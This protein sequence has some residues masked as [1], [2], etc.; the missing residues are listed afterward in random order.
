[1][2]ISSVAVYTFSNTISALE[3][4]RLFGP[5]THAGLQINC[6]VQD[7][8]FTTDVISKSDIT[9]FQREF[10]GNFYSFQAVMA[11]AGESGKQVV[12]DLDD[13]LLSLPLSHPDELK[14]YFA[15]SQLPMLTAM[16]QVK[17]L[18]VTTQY[19]ANLLK[20]YN[21]N[22]YVLP[23]YL[24][25]KIWRFNSP[26]ISTKKKIRIIYMGGITH[27]HDLKML[28]PAIRILA[29]KYPDKL[30]FIFYGANLE[31]PELLPVTIT[32]LAS[33]T[34]VYAD[35][36]RVALTQLADIAIA[37]LEDNDFNRCKSNIKYLEYTA[38]GLPG[39]FSNV[40]PYSSVIKQGSNGFVA[41]STDDWVKAISQLIDDPLLRLQ[42]ANEAQENV[43][44]N[45]LMSDHAHLWPETLAEISKLTAPNE[46]EL[47]PFVSTFSSICQRLEELHQAQ[48][49]R[50]SDLRSNVDQLKLD[51]E[52]A[53]KNSFWLKNE[54]MTV[55][56]N[57]SYLLAQGESTNQEVEHQTLFRKET[58]SPE[59]LIQ[60]PS[61]QLSE[62]QKQ[63][64]TLE[65]E[66][67]FYKQAL[68][69]SKLELVDH[70]LSLSWQITRPF[71]RLK[72]F[73]KKKL[74]V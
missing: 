35:F 20:V 40:L 32:N 27:Q 15:G 42:I 14:L 26:Q 21:T 22:T 9:L 23:N 41:A 17:A 5:L 10:P 68:D 6:G 56:N 28:L 11:R 43:R 70:V 65:D 64:S 4:Y 36:A 48:G 52:I 66:I 34:Y 57:T 24:N 12:M 38:M 63:I 46:S 25:D 71:R 44:K 74:K 51:L 7:G 73:F 37:P 72:E 33:E 19:L 47:V 62:Y 60:D 69:L 67:D 50:E 2:T 29:L 8:A 1:M 45:W 58:D 53:A 16:V 55:N 30:E 31:L 49:K 18:A 39:V 13:D 54:K 61:A 59:T 3:D